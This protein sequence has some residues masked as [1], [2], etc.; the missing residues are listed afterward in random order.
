MNPVITFGVAVGGARGNRRDKNCLWAARSW[1]FGHRGEMYNSKLRLWTFFALWL[2]IALAAF[3][4]DRANRSTIFLPLFLVLSI[5]V[6]VLAM[7][8]HYPRNYRF[9]LLRPGVVTSPIGFEVRVTASLIQY[10]EGDHVISLKPIPTEELAKRFDVSKGAVKGWDD[11]FS[12][13]SLDEAKRR[14]I[15]LAMR[16]ALLYLQLIDA[17]K[18][19]PRKPS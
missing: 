5:A 3:S 6:I 2:V 9:E 12:G 19:V 7:R 11:P 4:L 10:V 13:D 14:E 15:T 18:V 8:K 17:G 1:E 16:S